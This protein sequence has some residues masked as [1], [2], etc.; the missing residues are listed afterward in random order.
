MLLR[1]LTG[2]RARVRPMPLLLVARVRLDRLPAPQDRGQSP[3]P[4]ARARPSRLCSLPLRL[5]RAKSSPHPHPEVRHRP[6]RSARSL[7]SV[8]SAGGPVLRPGAAPPQAYLGPASRWR[9]FASHTRKSLPPGCRVLPRS[10]HLSAP[11]QE[12]VACNDILRSPFLAPRHNKTWTP[13][14]L[15]ESGSESRPPPCSLP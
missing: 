1:T 14:S 8:T 12:G 13:P 3:V 6:S 9:T 11:P 10:G 2:T 4:Q 7:N 5:H 15:L